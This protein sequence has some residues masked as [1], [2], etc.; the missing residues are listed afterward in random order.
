MSK[1]NHRKNGKEINIE[2]TRKQNKDATFSDDGRIEVENIE[3]FENGLIKGHDLE[4]YEIALNAFME[5]L[6]KLRRNI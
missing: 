4:T 2:N 1:L 5:I 3:I 6:P